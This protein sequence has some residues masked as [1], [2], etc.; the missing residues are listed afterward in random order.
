M[1][2]RKIAIFILGGFFATALLSVIGLYVGALL[3]A[4]SQKIPFN[5]ITMFTL[6]D[7]YYVYGHIKKT[8]QVIVVCSAAAAIVPLGTIGLFILGWLESKK[9]PLH[10]NA[11]FAYYAELVF[12]GLVQRKNKKKISQSSILIGKVGERFLKLSGPRFCYLAAPSRT[13]KGVGIVIPNLLW[14]DESMVVFDPKMENW[15]ITAGYR[16]NTLKQKVFLFSPDHPDMKTHRWNPLSYIRRNKLYRVADIQNIA[17]MLYP[18]HSVDSNTAFFNESAQTLFL[19]LVLYLLDTP[20]EEYSLSNVV[21]LTAPDSGVGLELWIKSTINQRDLTDTPLSLDCKKALL[22]FATNSDNTRAGILASCIAPLN[23]FR[24]P[25]TAA[26]TSGDDFDLRDV[27]KKRMTIYVGIQARNTGKYTRLVNLFFSQLINENTHELPE[28]N[29]ALKYECLLL[30]DEFASLE[31]IG[32][33]E[34]SIAY[35][36]G[37][38]LRLLLI[39]QDQSQCIRHYTKEGARTLFSNI[40]CQ[41][42]FAPKEE[43]DAKQYSEMLGYTTVKSVSNSRQLVGKSSRSESQSDQRR[44]LLLPQEI[45]ELGSDKSI[46]FLENTK[47]I[48]AEKIRW[49]EDPEFAGKGY[50]AVPDVPQLKEQELFERINGRRV[51]T[52]DEVKNKPVEAI[53]NNKQ[54]LNDIA[55]MGLDELDLAIFIANA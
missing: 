16:A 6:F 7:Y 28:Q 44:A 47:P 49:Y 51:M 3:F 45:K 4:Q 2:A 13:G 31:R 36:A 39:F 30:I 33:I 15:D 37:Y 52:L 20:E 26:A 17:S 35:M 27:R 29:K 32:I 22:S 18:S 5:K 54:I 38:K 48:M 21:K 53:A 19:G 50:L 25:I 10:G 1:N 43:A 46:I 41:I 11:R 8:K 14:Y 9:R 42:I 23:I 40:A 55:K 12:A 24:D 34:K